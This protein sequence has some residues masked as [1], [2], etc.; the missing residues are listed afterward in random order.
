MEEKSNH[1]DENDS[2]LGDVINSQIGNDAQYVA[3]G[4]NITQNIFNISVGD[5]DD[6]ENPIDAIE[7]AIKSG[8]TDI[9]S[10]SKEELN[11]FDSEED[12]KKFLDP[13]FVEAAVKTRAMIEDLMANH[14]ICNGFVASVFSV[15]DPIDIPIEVK[16]QLLQRVDLDK[17]RLDVIGVIKGSFDADA[18]Q[19]ECE[20]LLHTLFDQKIF[21]Q[22]IQAIRNKRKDGGLD[23]GNLS[24]HIETA[25]KKSIDEQEIRQAVIEIARKN[26]VLQSAQTEYLG[27]LAFNAVTKAA[28]EFKQ[29]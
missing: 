19:K 18:V 4:K 6:A 12:I 28:K 26:S 22:E 20:L 13:V 5:Q 27:W 21:Q 11:I 15:L 14:G 16:Y 1:V 3:T 17:L 24:V 10:A 23:K 25:I 8:L 9:H 7:Q 2:V 29:V